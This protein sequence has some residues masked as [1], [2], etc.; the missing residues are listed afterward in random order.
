LYLNGVRV[1]LTPI[2]NQR[3]S[4]GTHRLRVEQKGYRTVTE[5]IVVKGTA[6]VTRRYQL[7]RGQGR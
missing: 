3:L 6:P 5:T 1:G 4:P 7:R 2:T